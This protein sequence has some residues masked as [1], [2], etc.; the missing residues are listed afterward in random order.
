MQSRDDERTTTRSGE[1]IP[2]LALVERLVERA[3]IYLRPVVD[4]VAVR[5]RPGVMTHWAST[6]AIKPLMALPPSSP[7]AD[8][9]TLQAARAVARRVWYERP[10]TP[11]DLLGVLQ[12]GRLKLQK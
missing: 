4:R 8:L 1:V 9:E 11:A 2:A 3:S 5:A 10:S 7:A 6:L 12:R